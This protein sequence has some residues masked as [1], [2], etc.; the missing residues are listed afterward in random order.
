MIVHFECPPIATASQKNIRL[1]GQLHSA[2]K[3]SAAGI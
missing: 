2:E 1:V 3:V